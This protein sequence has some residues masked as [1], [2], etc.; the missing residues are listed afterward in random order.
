MQGLFVGVKA[1]SVSQPVAFDW[2]GPC[3]T[4]ARI[5]PLF[6]PVVERPESSP[7]I[8][9]HRHERWE[10]SFPATA[11]S[12]KPFRTFESTPHVHPHRHFRPSDGPCTFDLQG[13]LVGVKAPSLSPP[14]PSD[15]TGTHRTT[16][17]VRHLFPSLVK[18][19][20]K[21]CQS[22]VADTNTVNESEKI[23]TLR[24]SLR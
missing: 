24:F 5:R 8:N 18:R 12:F 14:V 1:P 16:A 2:S 9:G 22:H 23:N 20:T 15:R 4:T 11:P 7:S 3:G 21:P 17:T 19:L 10:R 13:L 6:L